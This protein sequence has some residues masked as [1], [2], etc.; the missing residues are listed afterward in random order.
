MA[1]A[2]CGQGRWGRVPKDRKGRDG[3]DMNWQDPGEGNDRA[4]AVGRKSKRI[5]ASVMAALCPCRGT[6]APQQDWGGGGGQERKE[7]HLV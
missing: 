1:R 2:G 4:K 6:R 3:P 5:Q 7:E